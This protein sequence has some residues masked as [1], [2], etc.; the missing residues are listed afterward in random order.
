MILGCRYG[1]L[2]WDYGFS[3]GTKLLGEDYSFVG[4]DMTLWAATMVF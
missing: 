4:L 3:F 1:I 2:G